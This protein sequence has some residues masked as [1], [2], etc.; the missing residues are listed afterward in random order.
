MRISNKLI[1]PFKSCFTTVNIISSFSTSA[2]LHPPP[3][4]HTDTHIQTHKVVDY[5]EPSFEIHVVKFLINEPRPPP[6][7]RKTWL[8]LRPPTP[9]KKIFWI[10]AWRFILFY[11]E[12]DRLNEEIYVNLNYS[13]MLNNEFIFIMFQSL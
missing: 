7:S 9:S 12:T 5:P 13:I 1:R 4:H 2:D 3:H 11:I 6:P 8:S 10:R